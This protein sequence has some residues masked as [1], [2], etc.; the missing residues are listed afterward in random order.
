MARRYLE[1]KGPYS[2]AKKLTVG[3]IYD[4]GVQTHTSS[5]VIRGARFCLVRQENGSTKVHQIFYENPNI[6]VCKPLN[7]TVPPPPL[8][9]LPPAIYHAKIFDKKGKPCFTIKNH[10]K[11]KSFLS[12]I[13]IFNVSDD[14]PKDG[15]SPRLW[16]MFA[17][18]IGPNQNIKL[19]PR[20][21]LPYG[22]NI[23]DAWIPTLK[24]LEINKIY[25]VEI[26]D[27]SA[28]KNRQYNGYFCMSHTKNGATKVHE[29][30]CNEQKKEWDFE[31]CDRLSEEQYEE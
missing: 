13:R 22:I 24:P 31:I 27:T 23:K 4:V 16:D 14:T 5:V 26:F 19:D 10:E 15:N 7:P 20:A 18:K 1:N 28:P 21:C 6:D 17:P 3:K 8:P 11:R 25:K 29:V 30:P 2:N 9:Q 12:N